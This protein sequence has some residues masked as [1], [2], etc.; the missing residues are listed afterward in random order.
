MT[1]RT[2][3]T[4]L[5]PE[6]ELMALAKYRFMR[7]ISP[8][9]FLLLMATMMGQMVVANASGPDDAAVVLD[10]L[11]WAARRAAKLETGAAPQCDEATPTRTLH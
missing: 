6:T 8:A 7:G 11:A 3:R 4:E 10:S 9:D 1:D 5:N 2:Y